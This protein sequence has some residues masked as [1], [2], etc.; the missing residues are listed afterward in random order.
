VL[1]FRDVARGCAVAV[2]ACLSAVATAASCA[3]FFAAIAAASLGSFAPFNSF[4]SAVLT[5]ML[6]SVG[7]NA[8]SADEFLATP[9]RSVFSFAETVAGARALA[10]MLGTLIGSHLRAW[11]AGGW[12]PRCSL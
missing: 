11:C 6:A 10:L 7:Q 5:L 12:G 3:C 9:D 4:E 1:L 2:A 8:A